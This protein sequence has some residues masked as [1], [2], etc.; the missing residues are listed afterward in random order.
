MVRVPGLPTRTSTSMRSLRSPLRSTPPAKVCPSLPNAGSIVGVP[1]FLTFPYLDS[2][3][4]FH[5]KSLGG[6]V[7]VDELGQGRRGIAIQIL[8]PVWVGGNT[9]S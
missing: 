7:R 3:G 2:P 1:V 6:V 9:I 8:L 5:R 4:S